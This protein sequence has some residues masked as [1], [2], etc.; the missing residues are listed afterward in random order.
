MVGVGHPAM[1]VPNAS[2]LWDLRES[3]G[4]SNLQL[5]GR[6]AGLRLIDKESLGGNISGLSH[7]GHISEIQGLE[8]V[9]VTRV[10]RI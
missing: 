4:P 2:S 7:T 9:G 1:E 6:I 10:L 3:F 8:E 5:V